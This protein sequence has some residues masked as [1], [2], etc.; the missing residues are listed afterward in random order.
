MARDT[1]ESAVHSL[2][3]KRQVLIHQITRYAKAKTDFNSVLA[4]AQG[5][6]EAVVALGLLIFDEWIGHMPDEEYHPPPC[7]CNICIDHDRLE[8]VLRGGKVRWTWGEDPVN[9]NVRLGASVR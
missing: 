3:E 4:A 1:I 8:G 9:L 7:R 6:D 5:F 2:R